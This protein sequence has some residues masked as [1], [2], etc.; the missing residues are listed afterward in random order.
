MEDDPAC[1]CNTMIGKIQQRGRNKGC[2]SEGRRIAEMMLN[3]QNGWNLIHKYTVGL[4]RAQK[5]ILSCR[6]KDSMHVQIHIGRY[7]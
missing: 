7:V 3:L 5:C 1:F 6:R 4:S 2:R